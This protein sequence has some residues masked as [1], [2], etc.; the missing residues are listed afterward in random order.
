MYNIHSMACE[1]REVSEL[2]PKFRKTRTYI[3]ES[4]AT[5]GSESGMYASR[6]KATYKLKTT[7]MKRRRTTSILESRRAEWS[8]SRVQAEYKLPGEETY[9]LGSRSTERSANELYASR[10]RMTYTLESRTME[11]SASGTRFKEENDVH[12]GEQEQERSASGMRFKEENDVHSGEQEH[13]KGKNDV[14]AGDQEEWS[15]SG[16]YASRG[17][18]N[19]PSGEQEHG[20]V[21]ERNVGFQGIQKNDVQTGEQEHGMPNERNMHFQGRNNVRAGQR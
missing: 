5:D 1:H 8:G 14:R 16:M 2:G 7:S 15:A 18:T 9:G 13:G 17:I 21:S 19:V 4:R 6:G 3:L 10:G 20:T 11:R 12:S